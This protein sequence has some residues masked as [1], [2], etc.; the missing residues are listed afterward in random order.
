MVAMVGMALLSDGCRTDGFAPRDEAAQVAALS[1]EVS[2]LNHRLDRLEEEWR[3]VKSGIQFIRALID[4]QRYAPVIQSE[5][6]GA[7]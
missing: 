5:L 7:P 4:E 2:R 3:E 6:T 1:N